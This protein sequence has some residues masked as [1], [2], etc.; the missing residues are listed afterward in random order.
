MRHSLFAVLFA[1]VSLWPTLRGQ[2]LEIGGFYGISN[3]MGDL[4][5]VRFEV[6]TIQRAYG[7]YTKW[8]PTKSLALKAQLYKG[9]LTGAD[10]NYP[11][12]EPIRQRNLSF[13]SPIYEAAAILE[14]HF[15]QFGVKRILAAPFFYA[16]VAAFHFNPKTVY[17]GEWVA[18]Q[19]LGT[20]GQGHQPGSPTPYS[21]TQLSLP[22]GLGFSINPTR[23]ISLS[24]ELGFRKTWTD[25]LD[26]VS[27]AYPD[28]ATLRESNPM[29][30][31]LS[32][33]ALEQANDALTNPVGQA[34]GNPNGKNDM[35]FFAGTTFGFRLFTRKQKHSSPLFVM[36]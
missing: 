29:A 9:V 14:F 27:G 36:N 21:L 20:E 31:A 11:T 18:L 4:Q 15:L 6:A 7:L 19:P 30:A 13:R 22:F 16:G 33:R 35:Y 8:F 1:T 32:Y 3:Y 5:Q 24:F 28:L 23:Q 34:R 25:Y 12:L 17:D 2:S 26:D 10:A